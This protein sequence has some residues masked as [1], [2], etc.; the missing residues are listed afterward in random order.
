MKIENQSGPSICQAAGLTCYTFL[1]S[2]FYHV[3]PAAWQPV[4]S[5][6]LVS[7][8][9]PHSAKPCELWVRLPIFSLCS[10]LP[11]THLPGDTRH[12]SDPIQLEM[13]CHQHPPVSPHVCLPCHQKCGVLRKT[14][15]GDVA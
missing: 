15:T 9:T 5:F 12:D 2:G 6:S 13:P 4:L 14:G 8:H 1:M 10:P 11:T 7:R 3:L